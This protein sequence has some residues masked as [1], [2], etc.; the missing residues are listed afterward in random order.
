MIWQLFKTSALSQPLVSP[1]PDSVHVAR[2]VVRRLRRLRCLHGRKGVAGWGCRLG[3]LG[4]QLQ[5]ISEILVHFLTRDLQK[6][7]LDESVPK[8]PSKWQT[9]KPRSC[10]GCDATAAVTNLRRNGDA[11]AKSLRRAHCPQTIYRQFTLNPVIQS[12]WRKLKA[13]CVRSGS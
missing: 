5:Q 1:P 6:V 2:G 12:S 8:P 9:E 4:C 13:L 11:Q 10:S 3:E 7:R